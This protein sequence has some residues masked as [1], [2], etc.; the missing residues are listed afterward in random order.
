MYGWNSRNSLVAGDE[1]LAVVY[2]YSI[3][4]M[5][6]CVW[7]ANIRQPESFINSQKDRERERERE[8]ERDYREREKIE[9][10][11]RKRGIDCDRE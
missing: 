8:R 7:L 2:I 4:R 9:K 6:D 10:E 1:N 5:M 3:Y 11:R